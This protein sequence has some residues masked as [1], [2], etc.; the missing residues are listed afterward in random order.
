MKYLLALMFLVLQFVPMNAQN[1]AA[2]HDR[3]DRLQYFDDGDF[4]Q[5]DHNKAAFFKVGGDFIIYHNS[6]DEVVYYRKG[7]KEILHMRD[8]LEDYTITDHLVLLE[9]GDVFT[10]IDHKKNHSLSLQENPVFVYG[11]SIV[12]FVDYYGGLKVFYNGEKFNVDPVTPDSFIAS[13][14]SCAYIQNNTI[15]KFHQN[16]ETWEITDE[17][18]ENYNSTNVAFYT[19]HK[20]GVTTT[21]PP[22][23]VPGSDFVLFLDGYEEFKMWRNDEVHELSEYPPQSYIVGDDIA[24]YIDDQDAFYLIESGK[25]EA[26]E[27]LPSAPEFYGIIDNTLILID[28]QSYLSVYWN[29]KFHDI[30]AYAPTRYKYADGVL[31][32]LDH[33]GRLKAFYEGEVVNVSS[34]IVS[35]FMVYGRVILFDELGNGDY[36][37]FHN[38][39]IQ[40]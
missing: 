11:D 38:G 25:T 6:Q 20:P 10:V 31:A 40:N 29:G 9:V 12:A 33:D 14:N 37:V 26:V 21:P 8:V 17:V 1:V 35:D 27:I 28:D 32:Y 7:L 22:I 4:I 18:R 3:Q 16:G 15:L 5:L 13:D 2:W 30:E 36:K 39:Q 34:D 24:A 23:Y 19:S